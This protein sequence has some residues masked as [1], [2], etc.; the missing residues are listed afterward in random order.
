M[1]GVH[2]IGNMIVIRHGK[3][4]PRPETRTEQ[5]KL[6]SELTSE[7]RPT[8]F[9][10]NT[11][12]NTTRNRTEPNRRVNMNRNDPRPKWPNPFQTKSILTQPELNRR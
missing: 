6:I 9:D 12:S 8:D 5:P 4:N 3:T 7:M 2:Y 1:N 11:Q 10:P